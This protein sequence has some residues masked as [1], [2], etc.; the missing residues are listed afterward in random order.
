M[1]IKY[2]LKTTK[3]KYLLNKL[4]IILKHQIGLGVNHVFCATISGIK[5]SLISFH[6]LL[7]RLMVV[8]QLP[9]CFCVFKKETTNSLSLLYV[10]NTHYHYREEIRS[11][12]LDIIKR[13][14]ENPNG[15]KLKKEII[16]IFSKKEK[17]YLD[18]ATSQDES[19][20]DLNDEWS[21]AQYYLGIV[22]VKPK[23]EV[24]NADEKY[25]F[26]W[27][28]PIR[29][30]KNIKDGW[31]V[32]GYKLAR[33]LQYEKYEMFGEKFFISVFE[34]IEKMQPVLESE[35]LSDVEK[36]FDNESFTRIF[37][38]MDNTN[39]NTYYNDISKLYYSNFLKNNTSFPHLEGK[40][41][42]DKI[43]QKSKPNVSLVSDTDTKSEKS[44]TN[45]LFFVRDYDVDTNYRRYKKGNFEGYNYRVRIAICSEQSKEITRFL[46]KKCEEY[47]INPHEVLNYTRYGDNPI[48]K[49]VWDTL[50]DFYNNDNLDLVVELIGAH[51]TKYTMSFSDNCFRDCITQYTTP[52]NMLVG[53]NRSGLI[54]S[55]SLKKEALNLIKSN[56]NKI[57]NISQI[58]NFKK[59]IDSIYNQTPIEQQLFDSFRAFL[60]SILFVEMSSGDDKDGEYDLHAQL[61][62]VELGGKVWGVVTY[63]TNIS[64]ADKIFL[65]NDDSYSNKSLKADIQLYNGVFL[66]NFNQASLLMDRIKKNIRVNMKQQ[67]FNDISALYTAWYKRLID[68]LDKTD[69]ITT[70]FYID[71]VFEL[72]QQLIMLSFF[73][74]YKA[75]QVVDILDFKK[76]A[77]SYLPPYTSKEI[78]TS[79]QSYLIENIALQFSYYESSMFSTIPSYE[80]IT[81]DELFF[82]LSDITVRLSNISLQEFTKYV[83][84]RDSYYR[85]IELSELDEY[86]VGSFYK[87]DSIQ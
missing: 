23:G 66:E 32:A 60:V 74:P 8:I 12:A 58:K 11:K 52:F 51:F 17:E 49:Y 26:D 85:D 62:P 73:Y 25:K 46:R 2:T 45:F 35:S 76:T 79:Y 7:N 78:E 83:I 48:K 42:L 69:V 61:T 24:I 81:H 9:V 19:R 57:F 75:V 39:I 3:N 27:V 68:D 47:M 4:D 44:L 43:F 10:S 67:F 87:V 6:H 70:D 82:D 53:A 63:V 72:N 37:H 71:R 14:Q 29:K 41:T 84:S 13:Y 77:H 30:I 86:S 65:R 59:Y 18:T 56:R 16:P 28:P 40:S 54:D 80:K 5:P 21:Q 22:A 55:Q 64:K 31:D 34:A 33:V 20:K 15:K 50:I 38:G 36:R 1:W